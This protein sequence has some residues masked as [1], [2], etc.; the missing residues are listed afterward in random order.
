M[1]YENPHHFEDD[2]DH[3]ATTGT[4]RNIFPVSQVRNGD[5]KFVA[6]RTWIMIYFES[7]IVSHILDFDFIVYIFGHLDV[8]RNAVYTTL[9]QSR[10]FYYGRLLG[11]G[12]KTCAPPFRSEMAGAEK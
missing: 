11:D 4:N 7:G 5:F 8:F 12:G 2:S 1:E 10:L 9:C 3:Q 6:T